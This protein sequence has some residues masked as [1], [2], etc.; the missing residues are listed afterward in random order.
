MESAC[1]TLIPYGKD[2]KGIY[3][4]M[5]LERERSGS[6]GRAA[7]LRSLSTASD[8]TGDLV[9][10]LKEIPAPETADGR[11]DDVKLLLVWAAEHA[12]DGLA[13]LQSNP[14]ALPRDL[15]LDP[16]RAELL[17]IQDAVALAASFV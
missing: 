10:K 9:E 12:R 6:G 13:Q 4:T 7:I 8:V 2:M 15:V 1:A 3:K 11:S 5:Q 14:S 17:R 16:G